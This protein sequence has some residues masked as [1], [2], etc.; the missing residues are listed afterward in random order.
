MLLS[1]VFYQ[2]TRGLS[3]RLCLSGLWIS[4]TFT[5][6]IPLRRKIYNMELWITWYQNVDQPIGNHRS[7]DCILGDIFFVCGSFRIFI[8]VD[9][10]FCLCV[11]I[12]VPYMSINKYN[13]KRFIAVI[14][15]FELCQ[16][17]VCVFH[18]WIHVY[19]CKIVCAFVRA[20]VYVSIHVRIRVYVNLY[21]YNTNMHAIFTCIR[22]LICTCTLQDSDQQSNLVEYG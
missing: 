16:I 12:P 1:C 5:S 17:G 3:Y 4:K 11:C 20:H 13:H 6:L 14:S 21:V 19:V 15:A 7:S 18:Y 9:C 22:I 8:L 10:Q 2:Q